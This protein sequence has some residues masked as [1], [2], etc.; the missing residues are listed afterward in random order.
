VLNTIDLKEYRS[1]II[2]YLLNTEHFYSTKVT[3]K[4]RLLSKILANGLFREEQ[5][6]I[7]HLIKTI[8]VNLSSQAKEITAIEFKRL[9]SLHTIIPVLHEPFLGLLLSAYPAM[10]SQ[11]TVTLND[12][13]LNI[14]N[15]NISEI[16]LPAIEDPNVIEGYENCMASLFNKAEDV[17]FNTLVTFLI[18]NPV[19][20]S[21]GFH[22][23]FGKLLFN[24]MLINKR[25]ERWILHN[26]SNLHLLGVK[27]PQFM[28]LQNKLLDQNAIVFSYCSDKYPVFFV[29]Q[30]LG[31]RKVHRDALRHRI[32]NFMNQSTSTRWESSS[33]NSN[34]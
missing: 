2:K 13:D 20:A 31:E 29:W 34:S 5:D 24:L 9:I 23:G 16:N 17:N 33:N 11:G 12:N 6:I 26:F 15:L 14:F 4:L 21:F 28:A 8:Q 10:L 1:E 25:P 7:P 3:F 30:Q 19:F 18:N 27:D 32:E 22:K